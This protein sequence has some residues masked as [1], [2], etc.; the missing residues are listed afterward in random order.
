MQSDIELEIAFGALQLAITTGSILLGVIGYYLK[1]EERIMAVIWPEYGS[2]RGVDTESHMVDWRVVFEGIMGAGLAF[3]MGM[4]GMSAVLA[5]GIIRGNPLPLGWVFL[6]YLG[7]APVGAL[8][9]IAIGIHMRRKRGRWR[10]FVTVLAFCIPMSMYTITDN[11]IW[12]FV[13]F[14]TIF[15]FFIWALLPHT[16]F[17]A[18]DGLKPVWTALL[19]RLGTREREQ[20][21]DRDKD[22]SD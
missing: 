19:V 3:M 12:Y 20:E 11:D 10:S 7:M 18:R 16:S 8:V 1:N 15:I 13:T 17:S 21:Q 4:I 2:G 9:V 6:P 14:P 22:N 5:I